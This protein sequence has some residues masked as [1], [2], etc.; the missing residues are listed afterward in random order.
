MCNHS[1]CEQ[2]LL[3]ETKSVS[4]SKGKNSSKFWK[5]EYEKHFGSCMLFKCNNFNNIKIDVFWNA[6]MMHVVMLLYCVYTNCITYLKR[7]KFLFMR[8]SVPASRSLFVNRRLFLCY[9]SLFGNFVRNK[10]IIYL[11]IYY[12]KNVYVFV[13]KIKIEMC[14][15]CTPIKSTAWLTELWMRLFMFEEEEIWKWWSVCNFKEKAFFCFFGNFGICDGN[16]ISTKLSSALHNRFDGLC[17]HI[18]SILVFCL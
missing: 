18:I 17:L 16:W 5:V 15:C 10:V 8:S 13:S 2:S 14:C 11:F 3:V 1:T 7:N 4:F 12:V 6:C 9:C